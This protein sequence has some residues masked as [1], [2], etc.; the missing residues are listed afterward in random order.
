MRHVY[1]HVP[2]CR[3]RCSYCDFSIAV[4]RNVPGAA[5]VEA[6]ERE[7]ALVVA[8]GEWDE[9]PLETLYFGGGTPSLL[10]SEAVAELVEYFLRAAQSVHARRPASP[11]GA[12][13]GGAS[14]SVGPASGGRGV[15]I[16][17]EANPDDVTPAAAAAWCAAGI[18]RVSLGVQSFRDDVLAWMHRTH[19]AARAEGAVDTLRAAGFENLSLDLIFALP[20]ALR[21]DVALDLARAVALAPAHLSVY[22]LSV[23]PRTP[24]ARWVSRGALVPSHERRYAAEFLRTHD[25]LSAAGFEHY[26]VSNYARPGRRSR[27]NVAYWTGRPY[28]GLGPSAHSFVGG[29]RRWN[30]APWA[31]YERALRAGQRPEAERERLT[32]EQRRIES[33]YLGLRTTVGASWEHGAKRQAVVEQALRQGWLVADGDHLRATPG[34]WLRL[35][36]I[37]ARLTT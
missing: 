33:L 9:E 8:A 27:H 15:E 16:T 31:A 2:F 24:L 35:D 32:S 23:E 34:G 3:R 26:E 5:Y 37:V 19:D 25:V 11:G 4:R 29:V 18:N 22:G 7:H 30:L 17:L 6:V 12:V 21:S 36:E 28:A 14:S 20:D 13:R 10:P 1:L